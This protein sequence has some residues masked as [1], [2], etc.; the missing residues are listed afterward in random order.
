MYGF[1]NEKFEDKSM[2]LKF[3]F[4][5]SFLCVILFDEDL[6]NVL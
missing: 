2:L 6:F 1:L 3:E 4:V 5:F